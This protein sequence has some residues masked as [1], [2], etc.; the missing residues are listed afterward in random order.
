MQLNASSYVCFLVHIKNASS[1][2][3]GND[4]IF[5]ARHAETFT[6]VTF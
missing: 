5:Q 3:C 2:N 1:I 4:L 6:K